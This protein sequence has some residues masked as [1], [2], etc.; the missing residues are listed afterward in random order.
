MSQKTLTL[1]ALITKLDRACNILRTKMDASDY[2]NYIFALL[3]LKRQSDEFE[4]RQQEVIREQ[5]K[6]GRPEA[7][8]MKEAENP[9][10][11]AGSDTSFFVP[12][13]ARW[14]NLEKKEGIAHSIDEALEA[15]EKANGSALK[16]VL[17]PIK[18]QSTSQNTALNNATLAELMEHF[19]TM[20]LHNEAFEFPDLLGAAY[21]YLIKYFADATKKKGGEFYTPSQ[22]VRLMVNLLNPQEGHAIYD[23]TAGSG[24]MLIE[25]TRHVDEHGGD[26]RKCFLAGQ[27]IK[28][29]TWMICKMN[30]ILHGIS[31]A[32]IRRGD[33]LEDPLHRVTHN[34]VESLR[35][36]DRVIANPP[37]SQNYSEKEVAK[38]AFDR[39]PFQ[40]PSS[41]KKA[42]FMFVQHM[43]ASLKDDGMAAV[44]MPHGV[45][46]RGG[47]EKNYRTH[48]VEEGLLDA[49]IGLPSNLFYGTGIPACILV[50]G[51]AGREARDS[52]LFINA[53]HEYAALRN[54]NALRPEDV[55]KIGFAYRERPDDEPAYCRV[56]PRSELEENEFNLNIRRYVDNAPPPEPH[57]V[58]AHLHG[59]IPIAEVDG[60]VSALGPYFAAYAGLRETLFS[61]DRPGYLSFADTIRRRDDIK[62]AIEASPGVTG[63]HAAYWQMLNQWWNGHRARFEALHGVKPLEF[64]R[65]LVR[66]MLSA[67]EDQALLTDHQV[68]GAVAN[69]FD[70][71][72]ADIRSVAASGWSSVLI[73]DDQ[74]MQL[75][76]P[77][78]LERQAEIEARV[79]EIDAMFDA[80]SSAE[81]E[82]AD[83]SDDDTSAEGVLSKTQLKELNAALRKARA[84]LKADK[85]SLRVLSADLK[86]AEKAH[87]REKK[88]GQGRSG[89]FD[90]EARISLLAREK[91]KLETKLGRSQAEKARLEAKKAG[92]K[93]LED[94]RKLLKAEL[95]LI[96]GNADENLDQAREGIS[97]ADAK[98][99]IEQSRW[100]GNWW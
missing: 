48:L 59:G 47:E 32:D 88:A 52:V 51:K 72:A 3:F 92:H 82:D 26:S 15:I 2:K 61:A 93:A 99:A 83:D 36:F 49:V 69:Y 17:T 22:V 71:I 21:E 75:Y 44:V 37:F 40:M 39:F 74:L 58:R 80:A 78:V 79:L 66:S 24:G 89:G 29:P 34:E 81:N 18:F 70:V 6:K 38:K 11:Y 16:D 87:A 43:V 45:L 91:T 98:R 30:M 5:R 54:Q 33:T 63:A 25:S 56:V 9:N 55:E 90:W 12:A 19:E 68:R 53:D 94:E 50:I 1:N 73:P 27:E 42:D 41:G 95:K 65:E 4:R 100:R 31:S 76:F 8:V 13:E 46:F 10:R 85:K 28:P 23:P 97:E 77:E 64:Q 96:H 60:N 67:L 20:T 84:D 35:K 62:T 86:K 14:E 57:D 7:F